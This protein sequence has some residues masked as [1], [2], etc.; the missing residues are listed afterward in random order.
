MGLPGATSNRDLDFL[1]AAIP[2]LRKSVKG[3]RLMIAL[4]KEQ[5]KMRQ[6]L[7]REQS[8]IIKEN[9][10]YA[11]LDLENQLAS[12]YTAYQI[13]PALKKEAEELLDPSITERTWVE[14]DLEE[15]LAAFK[16]SQVKP[17]KRGPQ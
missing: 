2:G 9:G 16:N 17:R 6:A 3:N 11:P 5:H 1:I 12:F 8:R 4:A 15:K 14:S 13:D 10:G 7:N